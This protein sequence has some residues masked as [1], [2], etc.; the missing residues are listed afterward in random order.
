MTS[1][2]SVHVGEGPG[3]SGQRFVRAWR[4]AE[5]GEAGAETHLSFESWELLARTLTPKRLALLRHIHRHPATSV[6][7]VA[8]M[9]GRDY[10]RVHEDVE[11]LT[12]A[13]LIERNE[14]QV[15][16]DYDEI[17]ATIAL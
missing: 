3:A 15:R 8:R 1:K 2:V 17:R 10:K 9:V 14:G 5:Q 13:G 16:A 4:R 6:A 7:A 12:A 11:L